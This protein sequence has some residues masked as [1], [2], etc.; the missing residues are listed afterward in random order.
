M[1]SLSSYDSLN[2]QPPETILVDPPEDINKE[3]DSDGEVASVLETS[4]IM[5]QVIPA[6]QHLQLSNHDPITPIIPSSN[7]FGGPFAYSRISQEEW[8]L[9]LQD[10]GCRQDELPSKTYKGN[11]IISFGPVDARVFYII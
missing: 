1:S 2:D 6:N 10:I 7:N 4:K 9:K 3:N 5:N 11:K 8:E